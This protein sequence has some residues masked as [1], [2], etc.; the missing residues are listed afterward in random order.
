MDKTRSLNT[1]EKH[2]CKTVVSWRLVSRTAALPCSK[3]TLK[4]NKNKNKNV[5]K[6]SRIFFVYAMCILEDQNMFNH[7]ICQCFQGFTNI[8]CVL[9]GRTGGLLKFKS[10]INLVE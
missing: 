5:K 6:N 9:P 1:K 4:K 7:T 3:Q 2:G 8:I 10:L